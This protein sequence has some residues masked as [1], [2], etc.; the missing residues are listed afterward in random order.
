MSLSSDA[1]F[2]DP[3]NRKSWDALREIIHQKWLSFNL[4]MGMRSREKSLW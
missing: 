4:E 1:L 3:S 2:V